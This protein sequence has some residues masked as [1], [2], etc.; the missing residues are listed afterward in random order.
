M[1]TFAQLCKCA[2]LI[3]IYASVMKKQKVNRM[4]STQFDTV[5][6]VLNRLEK[7][8]DDLLYDYDDDKEEEQHKVVPDE[9]IYE[10][11]Q[12]VPYNKLEGSQVQAFRSFLEY[13]RMNESLFS[14][15]EVEYSGFADKNFSDIRISDNMR[16]MFETAYYRVYRKQWPFT[17]I[18]GYLYKLGTQ[19]A[20]SWA[21]GTKD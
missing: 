1:R 7:K 2:A 4:N 5:M 18:R 11:G 20:W 17:F 14:Q 10:R 12:K 3:A 8:V 16:R 15:K 6:V 21:D 13:V 9:S 19:K